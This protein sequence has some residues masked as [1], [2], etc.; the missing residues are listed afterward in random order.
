MLFKK[1]LLQITRSPIKS[2]LFFVMLSLI[3]ICLSLGINILLSATNSMVRASQAF[4]TI[5]VV[6]YRDPENPNYDIHNHNYDFS[7]IF[8]SSHVESYDQRVLMAGFSERFTITHS[9]NKGKSGFEFF[10]SVIEF[11]PLEIISADKANCRIDQVLHSTNAMLKEGLVLPITVFSQEDIIWEAGKR[12]I[13]SISSEGM[14]YPFIIESHLNNLG[15]SKEKFEPVMRI[16]TEDY[17]LN[18]PGLLWAHLIRKY[19]NSLY[20][21]TVYLTDNLETMLIFHQRRALITGGRT[22]FPEDYLQGK[23]VCIVSAKLAKLS[24]LDLGDRIS[25]AFSET[26][27]NNVDSIFFADSLNH[28]GVCEE[29]VYEIVGLYEIV[30]NMGQGY[31][32]MEETIFI[33]QHSVNF[34]PDNYLTRNNFVSFRLTNGKVEAFLEEMEQY[35]L[36]GLSFTFY[37][38]GYS[39]VSGA[40]ASMKETAL[41]L[42]GIGATAG[43]GVIL[44]FSLLFVGRQKQNIA[45]MYSLGTSRGKA[46]SFLLTTVLVVAG[47][48]VA[49][50]GIT[51]CI[52]S[53][54]VLEGV[55][56][57]NSEGLNLSATYSEVYGEDNEL[58]FQTITPDK[59]IAPLAAAGTVLVVTLCLSGI[60]AAKVLRA[61]PMQVLSRKEE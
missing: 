4:S 39:K 9:I 34:W 45:I 55:Y 22:F 15:L 28:L 47:V 35:D 30:S 41:L 54:R 57:R 1:S 13:T 14:V 53:D 50:G 26:S 46:L 29:G 7:P 19:E 44:L 43:L 38:Q 10:S 24:G 61:E 18:G 25:L 58:D 59:P 3:T 20:T 51:G 12:Y 37:D 8:Y 6:E 56:A 16:D 52:L 60:F 27:P 11:T 49:I 23:P 42:T 36:P 40:L 21:A 2:S 31:G 5:G 17:L 48:S 33:P 32:L